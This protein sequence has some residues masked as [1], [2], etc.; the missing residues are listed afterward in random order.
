MYTTDTW[1]L[2]AALLCRYGT[3]A[4]DEVEARINICVAERD[5]IGTDSWCAVLGAM[6]ELLQ[7]RPPHGERIH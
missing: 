3:D 1:R 5:A 7:S 6:H 4:A 2:V